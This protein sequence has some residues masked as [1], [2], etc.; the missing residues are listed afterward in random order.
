MLCAYFSPFCGIL[1]S[2]SP[3]N[4]S[5]VSSVQRARCS[6]LCTLPVSIPPPA[7]LLNRRASSRSTNRSSD[8][9]PESVCRRPSNSDAAGNRCDQKFNVRTYAIGILTIIE[10]RYDRKRSELQKF[11]GITMNLP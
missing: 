3:Q 8:V 11:Q 7:S 4:V 6:R 10:S 9:T 1:L 5:Q 2:S